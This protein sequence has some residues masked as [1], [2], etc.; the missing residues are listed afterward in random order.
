MSSQFASHGD[1]LPYAWLNP[2]PNVTYPPVA[3]QVAFVMAD[4]WASFIATRHPANGTAGIAPTWLPFVPSSGPASERAAERAAELGGGSVPAGSQARGYMSFGSAG[5]AG[6]G[7]K[8][9]YHTAVC[10]FWKKYNASGAVAH[11][12]FEAFAQ[13]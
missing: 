9:D 6:I 1:E 3:L 8:Y 13:C 7:M 11:H 5:I 2:P 12:Q 10:S 4:Y